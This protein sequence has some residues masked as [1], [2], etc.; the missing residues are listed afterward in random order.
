V[1]RPASGDVRKA[2]LISMSGEADIVIIPF[3]YA[4]KLRKAAEGNGLSPD[5]NVR[6]ALNEMATIM[7]GGYR[8]LKG[9]AEWGLFYSQVCANYPGQRLTL[10]NVVQLAEIYLCELLGLLQKLERGELVVAQRLLHRALAETNYQLLHEARLRRG[11]LSF[12]EARRLERLLPRDELE[13]VQVSAQLESESLRQAVTKSY[14]T[15]CK[16][17]AELAPEWRISEGFA[18][19]LAAYLEP[20]APQ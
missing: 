14:A 12:R 15:M 7:R 1:V 10:E 2:T 20:S 11:Q 9:Q 5:P 13:L 3:S 6:F 17:L 8:F 18:K 4:N 16:L 19:L